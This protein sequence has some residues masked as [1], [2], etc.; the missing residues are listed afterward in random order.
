MVLEVHD[1]CPQEEMSQETLICEPTYTYRCSR[2]GMGLEKS[3][4]AYEPVLDRWDEG[5]PEESE[6]EHSEIEA[7]RL[8]GGVLGPS[9]KTSNRIDGLLVK[10]LSSQSPS[11]YLG[12]IDRNLDYLYTSLQLDLIGRVAS[13]V[14]SRK[15]EEM[16]KEVPEPV[17]SLDRVRP[18]F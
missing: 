16:P 3:A 17:I 12:D 1:R 11:K 9:A 15:Q 4:R 13:D 10:M 14:A 5:L 2:E 18:S 7:F 8:S 6:D